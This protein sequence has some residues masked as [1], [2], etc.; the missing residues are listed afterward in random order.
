M[1]VSELVD[2]YL[3][4]TDNDLKYMALRQELTVLEVGRDL[5]L[6]VNKVLMPVLLEEKDPEIVE[7]VSS[8]VYPQLTL[9]C[10]VVM[11]RGNHEPQ[12]F[13]D[14]IVDPLMDHIAD[15]RKNFI[16]QTLR[17]VLKV[18]VQSRY[19]MQSAGDRHLGALVSQMKD[20]KGNND[21]GQ[22]TVLYWEALKPVIST[23][24]YGTVKIP[25][26]IL[27]EIFNLCEGKLDSLVRSVLISSV[28]ATTRQNVEKIVQ[29]S[30]SDSVLE[31]ISTVWWQFGQLVPWL[32]E[33]RLLP[34]LHQ[35]ETLLTNLQMI[36]NLLPFFQIASAVS[37]EKG[38]SKNG[39]KRRLE[40]KLQGLLENAAANSSAATT[41][42][43][44]AE[45]DVEDAEVDDAQQAYLDE[46]QSD[47]D[48]EFEDEELLETDE[49]YQLKKL[50]QTI[51]ET[52]NDNKEK[53]SDIQPHK[54]DLTKVEVSALDETEDVVYTIQSTLESETTLQPLLLSVEILNQLLL[55][56]YTEIDYSP[57]CQSLVRHMK[58]NKA[59]LQTIK[60]GNLT[61]TIDDGSTLR[62]MVHST[63]LQIITTRK[64]DYPT[65]CKLLTEAV[66]RGARDVDPTIE[67]LSLR[68]IQNLLQSHYNTIRALDS[69][70]YDQTLLP[71]AAETAGKLHKR[72][73]TTIQN[74]EQLEPQAQTATILQELTSLFNV[75]YP[76]IE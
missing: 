24:Y 56:G 76:A 49:G 22:N 25:F 3:K 44:D 38:N 51:L 27:K 13:N 72:L 5:D 14:L 32:F 54:I 71:K 67:Q 64:L 12:W 7:L 61:Q 74:S 57:V 1:L 20:Y 40:S 31:A 6:L 28:Q 9:K 45:L 73:Q 30:V 47:D 55:T 52:L 63:I 66:S 36:Y 4:T 39:L 21:V 46:L 69:S 34:D 42:E 29:E 58:Q 59:F 48:L 68:I 65:C 17:N 16:V 62:T 23:Y 11:K 18:A 43:V 8:Q 60:V 10:I 37:G 26:A 19:R 2:Q 75:Q 70:W 15:K 33:K 53:S 50:C 41:K 35:Q